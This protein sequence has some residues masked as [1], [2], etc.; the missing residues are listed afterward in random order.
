MPSF[1][2]GKTESC[3]NNE[4]NFGQFWPELNVM[5]MF[6]YFKELVDAKM[7]VICKICNKNSKEF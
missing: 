7:K 6:E 1:Y 2:I 3:V 4:Q 5:F